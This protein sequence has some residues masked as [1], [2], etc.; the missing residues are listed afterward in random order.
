MQQ[1]PIL[2]AAEVLSW[3]VHFAAYKAVLSG[4]ATLHEDGP[5][6]VA[7]SA[8]FARARAADAKGLAPT[9]TLRDAQQD[10]GNGHEAEGNRHPNEGLDR[11]PVSMQQTRP[12]IHRS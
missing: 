6:I 2:Y 8:V 11:H 4:I 1:R 7:P 10:E 3:V 5:R 9:G 12:A